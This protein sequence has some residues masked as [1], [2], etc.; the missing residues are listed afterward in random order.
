MWAVTGDQVE[1]DPQ[2]PARLLLAERDALMPILRR[3]PADAFD[4]PSVCAG[5]S[6]RDVLAHCAAAL[7]RVTQRRLHTFTPAENEADVSERRDW[8]LARV[9][10]ELKTGY[11][12][13]GPEIAAADGRLDAIALGEWV[14]GG[15]VRDPLGEPDAY[16]S[17]GLDDALVLLAAWSR[18][19]QLPEVEVELP[20]RRLRLGVPGDRPAAR[21]VTDAGSLIR[22]TAGRPFHARDATLS[23]AEPHELVVF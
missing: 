3:T 17:A 15:D 2:R 8:P 14:H 1:R 16:A 5:W 4:R 22:L 7:T 12:T 21:L 18:H 13:A 9:L 10:D 6:V 19:K 11:A 20:G 23:G